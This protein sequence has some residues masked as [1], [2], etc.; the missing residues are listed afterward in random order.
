M[1]QEFKNLLMA[2]TLTAGFAGDLAEDFLLDFSAGFFFGFLFGFFD[3][4][5]FVVLFEGGFRS[6]GCAHLVRSFE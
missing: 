3:A 1:R 4:I 5:N 2:E 6:Q